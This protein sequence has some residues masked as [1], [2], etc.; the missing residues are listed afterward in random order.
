MLRKLIGKLN[1][2]RRKRLSDKRLSAAF[3]AWAAGDLPTAQSRLEA[4]LEDDPLCAE[5]HY[6]YG[7]LLLASGA[8]IK[9]REAFERALLFEPDRAAYS[10]GLADA[11][12]A[13]GDDD[14]A[15]TFYCRAMPH[16][17]GCDELADDA[18][19]PYRHAH[20]I[21][22]QQIPRLL[23]PAAPPLAEPPFIPP[24]DSVVRSALAPLINFAGL[25]CRR[26]MASRAVPLLERALKIEP[27]CG[28][29]AAM[30]ALF[31]CLNHDWER[32]IPAACIA[33]RAE[34]NLWRECNDICLLAAGIETGR[35]PGELDEFA[36]WS[37]LTDS[38][39]SL[40]VRLAGLPEVSWPAVATAAPLTLF[41]ACD[42]T[43]FHQY[44]VALVLSASVAMTGVAVHLHLFNASRNLDLE[45]KRLTDTVRG[46]TISVSRERVDFARH[47]SKSAYCQTM[48]FARLHQWMARYA[49]LVA[50]IDA[51]SLVRGDLLPIFSGIDDAALIVAPGEP[52]WHRHPAGVTVFRPTPGGRRLLE[53]M[54][55][56]MA[57]NANHG[58]IPYGLDQVALYVLARQATVTGDVSID[59]LD[60]S[61]CDT[62]FNPR[63]A[64]WSITQDKSRDSAFAR[65]SRELL[66]AHDWTVVTPAAA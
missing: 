41:I 15:F 47:G 60:G 20:P 31:F 55:A 22:L 14:A 45:I 7:A 59:M 63:S 21:W 35:L 46:T 17:A 37:A 1:I 12:L 57:C 44:T 24:S 13:V 10:I 66:A 5:A 8:G 38:N 58:T 52:P 42:E 19:W 34:T 48:R 4:L 6:W 61:L 40:A 64:V 56:V 2:E 9:A 54:A 30:L 16:V 18:S 32:V 65:E 62:Q 50:M 49:G 53:R 29:A 43:Y 39:T 23:V 3:I 11:N 26:G 36:D 28:P 25:L 33:K 27:Q 51:D